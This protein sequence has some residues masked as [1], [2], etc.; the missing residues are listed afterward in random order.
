MLTVYS[1]RVLLFIIV[2]FYMFI[3]LI[4]MKCVENMEVVVTTLR[5]VFFSFSS[6]SAVVFLLFL[7]SIII[8]YVTDFI[9]KCYKIL[10]NTFTIRQFMAYLQHSVYPLMKYC[11]PLFI[12]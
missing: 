10:D 5:S 11:C 12:H 8:V 6:F 4:R 9:K 1:M 7:V 3:A 2:I